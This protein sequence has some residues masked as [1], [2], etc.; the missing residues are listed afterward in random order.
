MGT[1]RDVLG[2]R[3]EAGLVLF[4]GERGYRYQDRLSAIPL[5]RLW[6]SLP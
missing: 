4:L 5:D 6:T 2:A 3:F 1:L